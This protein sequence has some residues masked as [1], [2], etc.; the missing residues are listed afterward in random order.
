MDLSII[1]KIF[2]SV[3]YCDVTI[4][5][6][7]RNLDFLV[8]LMLR[9]TFFCKHLSSIF[10]RVQK[11]MFRNART[12]A[13][14]DQLFHIFSDTGSQLHKLNL[15]DFLVL[16]LETLVG[17]YILNYKWLCLSLSHVTGWGPRDFSVT[18]ESKYL[19]WGFSWT[20]KGIRTRARK[21]IF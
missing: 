20:W 18:P 11:C 13:F 16:K 10:A 14:S 4:L 1:R 21:S 6:F 19:F 7:F 3:F 5:A 8:K 9:Y 15:K 17:Q 2:V 12:A